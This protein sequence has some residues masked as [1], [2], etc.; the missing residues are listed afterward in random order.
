MKNYN[1]CFTFVFEQHCLKSL[2]YLIEMAKQQIFHSMEKL[3]RSFKEKSS[4]VTTL[5][6]IKFFAISHFVKF[7]GFT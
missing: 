5:L 6:Y 4:S 3:L 7:G 1:E 2:K